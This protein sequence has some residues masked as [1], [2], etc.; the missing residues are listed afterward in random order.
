M[1]EYECIETANDIACFI[2]EYQE[3]GGELLNHFGGSLEEAI[4]AA[5]ENYCG[6]Y[7]SLADYAQELIEETT[8]IPEN[9]SYYI[10]YECMDR[11][12]ELGGDIFTIEFGYET[13]HIFWNHRCLMYS[14]ASASILERAGVD[15]RKSGIYIWVQDPSRL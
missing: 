4:T 11:N 8:Q 14:N 9:L 2:A 12:M 3:F 6:C 5:E 1:S 15:N 7:K 13:V 10:D